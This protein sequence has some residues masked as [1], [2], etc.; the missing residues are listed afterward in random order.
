MCALSLL[1]LGL[2]QMVSSTLLTGGSRRA[3][4]IT[5]VIEY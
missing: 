1:D 3:K 4:L 2:F 5:E